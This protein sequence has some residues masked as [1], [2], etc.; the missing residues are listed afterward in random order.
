MNAVFVVATG[1]ALSPTS[2]ESI[3][4]ATRRWHCALEIIEKSVST[5]HPACWK[6]LVFDK[7]DVERAMIL[8]ADTVV[9]S[10]CPNPFDSFDPKMLSVVSDRQTHQPARDRA[11]LDEWAIVA[12]ERVAPAQ[13][14][15]TGMMVAYRSHAALFA[16]A[17][18]LC[19]K[20]PGLAWHDQTPMNVVMSRHLEILNYVGQS[21]NYHNPNLRNP[22]WRQMFAD[23]YHF[24][25]NPDRLK[26]ISEVQWK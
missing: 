20:F 1:D 22:T 17:Y 13:Y 3:S 7:P 19:E 14:F 24:P 12:G 11:E 10:K 16:G 4:A 18:D 15:N 8:D 25:G 5:L 26:L 2:R 23:I 6:L 21:W 9:H